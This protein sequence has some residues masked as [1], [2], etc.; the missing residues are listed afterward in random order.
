MLIHFAA[1]F[2]VAL[3]VIGLVLPSPA[4]SREESTY[5]PVMVTDNSGVQTTFTAPPQRIV[6]LNPRYTETVFALGAGARL[7]GVDTY[8]NY[9]AEAQQ[10]QPRLTTYPGLSIEAVVG[11]Q[12]DLV[13]ALVERD[14]VVTPLRE[15][16]TPVLKLVPKDYEAVTQGVATLG[17]VLGAA[18]AGKTVA[19]TMGARRD[20][21]VEAVAGAS[22]PT[23]F[24]EMEA[25]KR[26]PISS[27]LTA[28]PTLEAHTLPHPRESTPIVLPDR[29]RHSASDFRSFPRS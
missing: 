8:S 28:S 19:A 26:L 6:S 1:R 11:L 14:D 20:A 15:H 13:L 29:R 7:V 25:S 12:P 23:A 5:E 9:P 24:Y 22:R 21:V 16:G 17:R 10:V 4:L 3:L 27:T 18:D 2:G